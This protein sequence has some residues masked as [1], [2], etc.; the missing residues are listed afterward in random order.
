MASAAL[1][2]TAIPIRVTVSAGLTA[3]VMV[4][5]GDRLA[6][7]DNTQTR[8]ARTFHLSNSRHR[9]LLSR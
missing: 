9:N 1:M 6:G 8:I 4:V 7:V 3:I 2:T 5:F